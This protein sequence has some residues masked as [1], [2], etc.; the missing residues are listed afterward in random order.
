MANEIRI[1]N[2]NFRRRFVLAAGDQPREEPLRLR[3][4]R[5]AEQLVA[6]IPLE[7]AREGARRGSVTR[8]ARAHLLLLVMLRQRRVVTVIQKGMMMV[9]LL[10]LLLKIR[11]HLEKKRRRK[12]RRKKINE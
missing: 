4:R 7:Q 3:T 9:L 10:L 1:R 12:N 6:E 8:Q 11:F 5:P 2:A